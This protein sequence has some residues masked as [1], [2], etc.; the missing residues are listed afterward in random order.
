MKRDQITASNRA[1]WEEAAPLHRQHNQADLLKAF[2]KPGYACLDETEL[3]VLNAIGFEGKA[4]AQLCCNNGRELVSLKNLGA[5]RCVG[6]EGAAGFVEQARELNAAAGRDC[7]F[8]LGDVYAISADYD[9]AFDLVTVTIGVFNWMADIDAFFAVA[10]RLLKP[11]GKLFVYEQHPLMD[12]V[13]PGKADDPVAWNYSYFRTEP[14]MYD[15]GLD[16]FGGSTYESEPMYEIQ[17]TLGDVLSAG[18]K[19]GLGLEH[20]REYPHHISNTWYNVERQGPELPMCYTLV[21]GKG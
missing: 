16:Y 12:M 8:V 20:F 2:A 10:A 1:A 11:G 3:A 18:L 15:E 7:T 19:A 5:G 13:E 6:F 17:H 14:R 4:V 21:M 9:G